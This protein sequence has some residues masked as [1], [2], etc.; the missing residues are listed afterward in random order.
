MISSIEYYSKLGEI[1]VQGDFNAYTNTAPDF[2]KS[3]DN[4]FP[5]SSDNN[6]F[7]VS[8]MSRNNQDKKA[9]N[10]SGKL[11]IE[12]CKEAGLRILNGRTIGDLHGKYTCITYN[13][14]SLVDYTLVLENMLQYIGHFTVHDITPISDHSPIH[15]SLLTGFY[16]HH[17]DQNT[18]LDPLLGKFIWNEEAISCYKINIQKLEVKKKFQEF[19]H[20]NHTDC[21]TAVSKLNALLYDTAL[22]KAK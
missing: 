18:H 22:M 20:E 5:K 4:Q 8:F 7:I 1:V 19:S 2:V 11:L 21:E 9:T 17:N 10:K 15:C 12:L 13:G 16:N 3:D 6:Y 14:C